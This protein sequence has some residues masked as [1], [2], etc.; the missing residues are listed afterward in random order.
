MTHKSGK[1]SHWNRLERYQEGKQME[2]DGIMN[3]E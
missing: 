1:Q 3:T 2:E